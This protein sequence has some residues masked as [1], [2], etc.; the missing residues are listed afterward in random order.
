M[1]SHC[2]I[3]G[4]G[5]IKGIV[6]PIKVIIDNDRGKKNDYNGFIFDKLFIFQRRRIFFPN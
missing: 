2:M 3:E 4:F 1:I 6:D 5:T